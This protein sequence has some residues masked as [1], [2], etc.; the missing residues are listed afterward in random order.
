[1]ADRLAAG[2]RA[3][4][5]DPIW[6]VEANEVFVALPLSIHRRLEAAGAS[7]YPWTTNGCPDGIALPPGAVLARLVTSFATT[8]EE[9]DR[10][11]VTARI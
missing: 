4:G 5:L 9:V 10:F 8:P 2:L 3:A 6:P 7:Y 1:M 11:L